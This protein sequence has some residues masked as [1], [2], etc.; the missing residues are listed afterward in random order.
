M[1]NFKDGECKMHQIH[2]KN[3]ALIWDKVQK[4]FLIKAWKKL[5]LPV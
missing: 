1:V 4:F 3:V 2:E 5:N